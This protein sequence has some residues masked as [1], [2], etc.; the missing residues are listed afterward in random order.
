MYPLR[1]AHSTAL[2][3]YTQKFREKFEM[4]RETRRKFTAWYKTENA[5]IR[6]A[7]PRQQEENARKIRTEHVAS[8]LAFVLGRSIVQRA[9][10]AMFF[11]PLDQNYKTVRTSKQKINSKYIQNKFKIIPQ[12]KF[13]VSISLQRMK[14]WKGTEIAIIY[15]PTTAGQQCKDHVQRTIYQGTIHYCVPTRR[16]WNENHT[17]CNTV[18]LAFVVRPSSA[19]GGFCHVFQAFGSKLQNSENKQTKNKLKIY[20]K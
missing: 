14:P 3:I 2:A 16:T 20:S 8:S 4:K 18:F 1:I 15:A 5:N 19:A 7:S 6:S 9:P 10:F 13:R 12:N 17:H 11:T